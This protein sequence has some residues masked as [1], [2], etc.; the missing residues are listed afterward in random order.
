MKTLLKVNELELIRNYKDIILLKSG[1]PVAKFANDQLLPA[2]VGLLSLTNQ[3]T[4]NLSGT[5]LMA[6]FQPDLF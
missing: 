5:K 6:N 3:K 4:N 2:I 1:I